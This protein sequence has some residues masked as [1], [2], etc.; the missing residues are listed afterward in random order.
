MPEVTF[1]LS[2]S[3]PYSWISNIMF[4]YYYFFQR[5]PNF[6]A[7]LTMMW[8]L[9][10]YLHTIDGIAC[11]PILNACVSQNPSDLKHNEAAPNIFG[12]WNPYI[13]VTLEHKQIFRTLRQPLLGE[14]CLRESGGKERDGREG[15]KMFIVPTKFC[16][17]LLYWDT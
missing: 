11:P 8:I 5:Q 3:F 14:K 13:V 1:H 12:G 17:P 10:C 6:Y 16:L 2:I 15:K 9:A 4:F 7:L